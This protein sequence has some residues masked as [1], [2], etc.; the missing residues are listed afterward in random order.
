MPKGVGTQADVNHSQGGNVEMSKGKPGSSVEPMRGACVC[1]G[2]R[3][4]ATD[5]PGLPGCDPVNNQTGGGC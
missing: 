1:N 3:V 4:R 5:T 2:T